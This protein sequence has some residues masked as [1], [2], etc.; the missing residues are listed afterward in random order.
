MEKNINSTITLNNQVQ[1][2]IMGLGTWQSKNNDCTKAV[3]FA[4]KNGYDHIDTAQIYG[5][6]AQVGQG[7][8]N[9]GR[10]RDEIFI[11]TKIW[12]TN[13]GSKKTITSFKKSLQR[14]QTDV[15]DLCLIHWP[16]VRCFKR[17]IE[18]WRALAKLLEEGK[19]RAIGVSNFSIPL[20][21]KLMEAT[22]IVPAVNQVEFNPFLYQKELLSFC[23]EKGIQIE[24]YSPLARAKHFDHEDLQAIA[25]KHDKSPAQI[26][27]A[28]GLHHDLV[29][30]PKSVHEARILENADS[31]FELDEEDMNILDSVT[32]QERLI[33]PLWA[34]KSW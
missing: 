1:I 7:W 9:S 27:L 18:T 6:E 33:K 10:S 22:D 34:P 28:W 24:A 11:T 13:Q 29:V 14:L 2:P 5:N 23:R 3:E 30:L 4:L 25:K 12:N 16:R 21:K 8:K 15:V 17:T 32:P 19:C 26:M 31:F 20:L